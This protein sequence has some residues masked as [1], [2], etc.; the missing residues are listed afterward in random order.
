MEV[1]I[2]FETISVFFIILQS[3]SLG[4]LKVVISITLIY[5]V[6]LMYEVG[7]ENVLL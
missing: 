4:L 1:C 5:I 7:N 3:W 6:I 2:K